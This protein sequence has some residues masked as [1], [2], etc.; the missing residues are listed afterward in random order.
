MDVR[1]G[2][3]HAGTDWSHIYLED[4]WDRIDRWEVRQEIE[5]IVDAL[6]PP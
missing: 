4:S 2:S 1:V 6:A 3:R 5:R